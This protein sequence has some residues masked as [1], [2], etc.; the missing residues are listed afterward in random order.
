MRIK[1]FTLMLLA[2]LFSVAGF[3]QKS[4]PV[5]KDIAFNRTVQVQTSVKQTNLLPALPVQNR[6]ISAVRTVAKA[7][8]KA[9]EVVTP[10]EDGE[11][12]YFT[13]SGT[14]YTQSAASVT[15]TVKVVWDGDDD[16]YISGLSYYIPDAFVKG[17][18]VD[19]ETVV[20]AAGQYMG[21]VG[22]DIYFGGYGDG[23][24]SDVV[25][26]FNDETYSF[27]FDGYILDNGDP[28]KLGF[29]AYFIPG[30]TI[31]PLEGP[32]EIPVEIP[33]DLKIETYAYSAYDYFED[34]ADVS[35]N[36]KIG[37]YGEDVYI[38]G[39]SDDYTEAW[40]KDTFVNDTTISFPS[41]QLL[42]D[43]TSLYFISINDN[44]D[45]VD[46]Y[47]LI[48]EPE[49]GIFK[50]GPYAPMINAYKDKL[51][52]SVWQFYYG[53]EI[54]KITEKA[55][56]PGMSLISAVKFSTGGDILEFNLAKVDTEGE[57][58]VVDKL[59]YKLYYQT[60][61]GDIVPVTFSK[62]LYK[63]L[64]EDATEIP[65]SFGDDYDFY[66]SFV[67]LNMEHSSWEMIGIQGIYYGGGER[68]ESE[69]AWYTPTWPQTIT[70]PE[71]LKD[72]VT[73]HT[74]KGE[75]KTRSGNVPFEKTVGIAFDGDDMYIR[76][77]GDTDETAWVK[78]TKV[79][80]DSYVFPKGQTMGIYGSGENSYRLFFVGTG[81][82]GISDIVLKID[83][84]NGVYVFEGDFLENADYTDKSYYLNYFNAG[85]TISIAEAQE[86]V[87]ELV[88]VPEGLKTESWTFSATE[89]NG[90]AVAK[91]VN[92]GF[93]GDDVYVQ[94]LSSYLP[95]AWVKGTLE[96][97]L[98]TFAAGQ[99]LGSYGGQDLWF[100][101][102][103]IE[104]FAVQDFVMTYDSETATLASS[105]VEDILGI[106]AYK[107]KVQASLYEMYQDVKIK[108][109]T[110][111]AATPA[112][113]SV[114][115]MNFSYYGDIIEFNIPMKDVDGDGLIEN[116]LSYKLYYDNGDG[117]PQVITFTKDLYTKLENDMTE[118][119]YGFLD[120][121]D[122]EG[123]PEGY[124]FYPSSVYLNMEHNT[125]KRVGIQTIYIGGGESHASEIG[126]YTITWPQ[127]V[128]LPDG[129]EVKLYDFTGEYYTRNGNVEFNKAVHVAMAGDDVFIQ[130]VG[131]RD[132][133]TWIKGTKTSEDTY[134]FVKGQ[135]LGFYEGSQPSD[136]SFLFL[137]GYNS[138]LGVLDVK[139]KYDAA[140][141]T[142]T[143]TTDIVENAD[144]TD[145]LYY[146]TRINAGAK[147]QPASEDAISTVVAETE[148]NGSV[149]H[150]IAGQ[151][152]SANFKGIVIK[153]GQKFF[154]K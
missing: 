123:N 18:F 124:D 74:F 149:R 106:N 1:N 51:E 7:P 76:G 96:D 60:E 88:V 61:G 24:L 150:N 31:S 54:K 65:A 153:N 143:A 129:A 5:K 34:G 111:K 99:Y 108:M 69:I 28:Q 49:T 114:N 87:P 126:W 154:Q 67:Y 19:D 115:N 56:T 13:L 37:F 105:V 22:A 39:M 33:N 142:F 71:A 86:E 63:N 92:V 118:I 134:T 122:E 47:I 77:V 62:D 15:R 107:A 82:D 144:Y 147:I 41:G 35:G 141:N 125:W 10:P 55:A 43:K 93:D 21:N 79:D 73:E 140:T 14:V 2:L 83:A 50:E 72:K 70:L 109:I 95:D 131:S 25:A 44:F 128:S 84:A 94:G 98:V 4:F 32:L 90:P 58:L 127:V 136:N 12:E 45:I 148:E 135:Y 38:Q 101:G 112:T 103:N 75:T 36:L 85:A 6:N 16:V 53:Y 152:V 91:N 100:I 130:G 30:L 81:S 9:A 57:G 133:E 59:A 48:Y 139:M 26:S 52:A 146:L 11:V 66:S 20:F 8:A 113:P 80:T 116:L 89:Y 119:P 121:T 110:E 102:F 137:M 145:K 23:V 17:T 120:N 64:E 42:T 68:N 27:T 40:I 132:E 138:T 97:G 3:A 151:R 46:E 78:G 29:Y 117:E 104:R